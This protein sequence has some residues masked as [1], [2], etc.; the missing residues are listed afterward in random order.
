MPRPWQF[1]PFDQSAVGTLS[2][3]LQ[4]SPV[5]AQVLAARGFRTPHETLAFLGT[6]LTELHDPERLPG[7][8]DAADRVVRAIAHKRRITV[9]GDYDVDGVTAVSLLWHCLKLAGANVDYYVP[10]RLEE[11][12][13]LNCEALRKLHEE[14]PQR[15]VITVDCGITSC[16]EAA[17]ARELGLELIVTDHHLQGPALPTPAC[18]VHPGLP[19]EYPWRELCGVGVAFKLAWAICARL[20]DG[21]RATPR[22]RE[23]LLSSIALAAM[24]TV[25]DVVPLLDENRVLVKHGLRS[26][27][28][29]A[30]IGLKALIQV[31]GLADKS[32]F[33]AEDIGFALAP[34]IN[35]VGRLGQARL[36]VE[37]LTT[38]NAERAVTLAQYLEEL[39]K[40]RQS[41]ERKMFKQ[42]REQLDGHPEWQT[43]K[44]CVLA[45]A[46]WH[47]GV[48]G[49][50][51]GRMAE[52]FS[53]P[54]ILIAVNAAEG[55]GQGSGRTF[56]RFDLHGGLTACGHHLLRFGGHRAAAG[57]KISAERIDA[58]RDE[59]VCHVANTYETTEAD[60]SLRIDAEV[61]LR[62][63]TWK[64]VRDLDRLGP[65]GQ[66]NPRPVLAASD[67]EL[68]GT[69]LKIGDG[70]RHLSLRVRQY[71]RTFK[72]I[73]FGRAEWADE[74]TAVPGKLH[75]AFQPMINSFRGYETVELQLVDW[76]PAP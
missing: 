28:D 54:A 43:Q 21:K 70:E 45:S 48:I 75:I 72:A 18:L 65:F 10:S 30:P 37:L 39:N 64:A 73:A 7:I 76:K 57:L 67:V 31:A 56:G 61:V 14:D 2:R 46:E 55:E 1:L 35:A 74:L 16:T 51:A 33:Q 71:N 63:L 68:D 3:E 66:A 8:P 23:F 12:Y 41:V 62:D 47:P 20:G 5:L 9:Y 19:G 29:R 58:F 44:A 27:K 40:E 6:K 53:R 17:L 32:D 59:F 60:R 69:P 38:D 4:V 26:L 22:M 34:R 36:A 25:A 49:I 52:H 42:A 15:L 11:G 50:V 13:G 24:G